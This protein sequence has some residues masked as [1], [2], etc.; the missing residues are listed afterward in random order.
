ME[1]MLPMQ[2]NY[3]SHHWALHLPLKFYDH[4]T[5]AH[6][7]MFPEERL[8]QTLR[9]LAGKSKR[10][11]GATL[12]KNYNSFSQLHLDWSIDKRVIGITSNFNT[13]DLQPPTR[14]VVCGTLIHNRVQDNNGRFRKS[15][16]FVLD[17]DLFEQLCLRLNDV[18]GT[19]AVSKIVEK[20]KYVFLDQKKFC[21]DTNLSTHQDNSFFASLYYDASTQTERYGYG[22]IKEIF[23]H[24]YKEVKTVY[25]VAEWYEEINE[26]VTTEYEIEPSNPVS[27]LPR[28]LPSPEWGRSIEVITN[29]YPVSYMFYPAFPIPSMVAKMRGNPQ[30][31]HVLS[32]LKEVCREKNANLTSFDQ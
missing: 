14:Q 31:K 1:I 24:T 17:D 19:G 12:S 4:G 18:T 8:H 25:V 5:F 32:Q 6:V 29:L 13:P 22:R 7:N 3:I 21:P 2:F 28:L 10:N 20:Y 15:N 11:I 16:E 26:F 9:K 27:G 30:R 23:S